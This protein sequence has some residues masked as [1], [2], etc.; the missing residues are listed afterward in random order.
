M[1][2]KNSSEWFMFQGGDSLLLPAPH[3]AAPGPSPNPSPVY[4]CSEFVF[5]QPHA[6]RP[7]SATCASCP[8]PLVGGR[9]QREGN[10]FVSLC[11]I[12]GAGGGSTMI[13]VEEV[14]L[15]KALP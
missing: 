12:V 4:M 3:P 10:V 11:N 7:G 15:Q 13:Q 2:Q 6:I 9:D 14:P 5:S 1:T 8:C